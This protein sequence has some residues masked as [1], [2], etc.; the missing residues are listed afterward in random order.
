MM[1]GVLTLTGMKL[2]AGFY[3]YLGILLAGAQ[4]LYHQYLIRDRERGRCFRAF[5][6]NNWVGLTIF[7]GIVLSTGT[8]AP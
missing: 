2:E 1:L 3:F 6:L 4:F 7:A 5:T 8:A